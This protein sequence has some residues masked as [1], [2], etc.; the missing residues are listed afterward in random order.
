MNKDLKHQVE[1]HFNGHWCT[2]TNP[3]RESA[4]FG[5]LKDNS[6][7]NII[8]KVFDTRLSFL[9]KPRLRARAECSICKGTNMPREDILHRNTKWECPKHPDYVEKRSVLREVIGE[10]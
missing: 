3:D 7:N 4:T 8:G 2:A 10:D 5:R 6:G 1:K 9:K